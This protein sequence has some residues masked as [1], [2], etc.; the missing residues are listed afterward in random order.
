M[1]LTSRTQKFILS[2][3]QRGYKIKLLRR[4]ICEANYPEGARTARIAQ[5]RNQASESILEL[6]IRR[7]KKGKARSVFK[8]RKSFPAKKTK[9]RQNRKNKRKTL[10]TQKNPKQ[11]NRRNGMPLTQRTQKFIL[12]EA[13]RGYKIKLLRRIICGAN[14]PEGART[15]RIA[16]KRNQAS[17]SILELK[18]RRKKR[19]KLVAYITVKIGE[20]LPPRK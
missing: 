11:K 15:A 16:R 7:K 20:K 2:E 14:Y 5:K 12:S 19:A 6:K 8:I 10:P 9:P 18:I 3:A 13:Q 4:I 17:E 1:P